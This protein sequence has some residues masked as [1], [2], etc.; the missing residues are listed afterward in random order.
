VDPVAARL[1]VNAAASPRRSPA[2]PLAVIVLVAYWVAVVVAMHVL[3]P[4]LD[5]VAVPLSVYVLGAHGEWMT[6]SFFAAAG[7]WLVLAFGLRRAVVP[8]SLSNAGAM[9]Y[10][11]AAC[12]DA[13]MGLVPTQYPVTPPLTR[14]G[15]IH[16]VASLVAFNAIAFG[17]LCFSRAFKGSAHWRPLSSIATILAVLMLVLLYAGVLLSRASVTGLVQRTLVVVILVW[18]ALIVRRWLKW[19]G[20]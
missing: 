16:L 19:S 1:N 3:Q 13:V 4:A 12:G 17:S 10:C 8:T 11:V 9:L 7:I 2:L 5:P 15:A 18:I 14:D 20:R 6:T